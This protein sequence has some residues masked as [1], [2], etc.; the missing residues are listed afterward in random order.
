MAYCCHSTAT[1]SGNNYFTK[2][3]NLGVRVEEDAIN[4]L[5]INVLKIIMIQ[6]NDAN[7][8]A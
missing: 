1:A 7:M 4:Y 2:D 6:I 8:I 5:I 3:F